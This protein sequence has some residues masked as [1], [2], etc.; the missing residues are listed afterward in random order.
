MI[1]RPFLTKQ[2]MLAI[3][4][5][6][7]Y[8]NKELLN[9]FQELLGYAKTKPFECVGT[10]KEARYAVSTSIQKETNLPYLLAYY[11]E[12]YPLEFDFD[13]NGYN[14]QNNLPEEFEQ[15]L[16]KELEKYV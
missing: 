8:E 14:P 3:F 12:H 6:D 10:Y 9:T 13:T 5:E 4:H 7:L 1:L 2:E 15:V 11:K 16:R